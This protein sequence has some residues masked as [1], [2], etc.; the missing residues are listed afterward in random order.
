MGGKSVKLKVILPEEVLLEEAA[1]KVKA[2]DERGSFTLLPRHV[3]LA[4]SLV[5]GILSFEDDS[6]REVF[7]ALDAGVLVKAGGDVLVCT[8]RAVLGP[9]L[10]QLREHV[11]E[12]FMVLDERE[13]AARSVMARLEAGLIRQHIRL[14]E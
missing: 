11:R 14:E 10:G 5:P 6:G 4:T 13:R 2:E 7:V 1:R 9:D 3:D 8:R 12:Q